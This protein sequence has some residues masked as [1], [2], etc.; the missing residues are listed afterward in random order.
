MACQFLQNKRA[1]FEPSF[2]KW[3][4]V[5]FEKDYIRQVVANTWFGGFPA[6]RVKRAGGR[7]FAQKKGTGWNDWP[8]LYIPQTELLLTNML[9]MDSVQGWCL[10]DTWSR[11]V[12]MIPNAKMTVA[13]SLHNL[14][15]RAMPKVPFYDQVVQFVSW[16]G[17]V[18]C[19]CLFTRPATCSTCN[20]EDF[21]L[22][23]VAWKILVYLTC[24]TTTS[25][26]P[27]FITNFSLHVANTCGLVV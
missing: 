6:V 13:D 17:L 5:V 14:Y 1:V 2:E 11:T 16:I 10:D 20:L 15:D 24:P 12:L 21:G 4:F 22:Y 27:A 23:L 25:T 3:F 9:Q 19:V 7:E 26:F 8:S 18:L